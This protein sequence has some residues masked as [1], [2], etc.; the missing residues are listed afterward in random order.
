MKRSVRDNITLAILRSISRFRIVRRQ[1]E[2]RIAAEYAQRLQV[3]TPSLEF[4]VA[5]LSGGN[6][7]KTVLAR[8]LASRSKLFMLDE[9]TRG[10]DVGAKTDIY[11]IIDQLAREGAAILVISSELPEALGLAD[12]IIVM[13]HGRIAGELSR[14]EA[15]EEKIL[16]LAILEDAAA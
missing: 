3:R 9:P 10:V 16:R 5:K 13:R 8:W 4:E 12:R 14:T 11:A 7:Q 2:R 1:E 15:T 6:Q